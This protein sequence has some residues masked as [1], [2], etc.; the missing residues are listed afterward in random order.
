MD[1]LEELPP[2][3]SLAAFLPEEVPCIFQDFQDIIHMDCSAEINGRLQNNQY[4][5]NEV[6]DD[7][8]KRTTL[9]TLR[10]CQCTSCPVSSTLK[11][12]KPRE[13]KTNDNHNCV[14]SNKSSINRP[15]NHSNLYSKKNGGNHQHKI[16][17]NGPMV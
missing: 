1:S 8:T 13:D 15:Y 9:S 6:T 5:N 2:V 11:T 14:R 17:S 3:D 16:C 12:I 10:D 4:S 7:A